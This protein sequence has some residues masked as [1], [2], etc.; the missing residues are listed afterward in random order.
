MTEI[1]PK[2]IMENY[3]AKAAVPFDDQYLEI[4][5]DPKDSSEDYFNVCLGV[6]FMKYKEENNDEFRLKDLKKNF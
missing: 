2:Y 5:Y 1:T 3:V 4:I 6:A